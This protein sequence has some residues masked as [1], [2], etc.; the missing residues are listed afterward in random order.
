MGGVGSTYLN[1]SE[2]NYEPAI[3]FRKIY[4]KRKNRKFLLCIT[5]LGLSKCSDPF[6]GSVDNRLRCF[7]LAGYDTF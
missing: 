1:N 2:N 6:K 3:I 7:V 5:F 4:A